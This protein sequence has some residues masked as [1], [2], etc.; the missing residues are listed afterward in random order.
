[1]ETK[2]VFFI[3]NDNEVIFAEDKEYEDAFN[4]LVITIE[5]EL[6]YT[7]ERAQQYANYLTSKCLKYVKALDGE[8]VYNKHTGETIKSVDD[9]NNEEVFEILEVE[10]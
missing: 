2:Y 9:L 5:N 10:K 8:E 3:T 1:M 6:G 7:K 4:C